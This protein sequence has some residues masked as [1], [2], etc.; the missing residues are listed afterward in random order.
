MKPEFDLPDSCE[1]CHKDTWIASNGICKKCYSE[2][3][4]LKADPERAKAQMKRL[5]KI[6]TGVIRFARSIAASQT[7]QR[8]LELKSRLEKLEHAVVNE[9]NR[10]LTRIFNAR[11]VELAQRRDPHLLDV[12]VQNINAELIKHIQ[13]DSRSIYGISP[14]KF[15]EIIAEIL[16][17]MGCD[18]K[19]M[20][21]TR[22]GG[23]DVLATFKTT[24]GEF[25]AIVQ[26]KRQMPL[27]KVGLSIVERFL[28]TI[29]DKDKASFGLVATTSFFTSGARAK[30]D[31]YKYQL[32]LADKNAVLR[33]IGRYGTWKKTPEAGIWIPN[34]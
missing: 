22:D 17:D 18:V 34:A 33:W 27:N 24:L 28:Y 4:Y 7:S 16:A 26:C 32:K 30:A 9:G 12:H 15:E 10:E 5:S 21:E 13:H 1:R 14:R 8:K 25:L 11:P 6:E 19:L 31:E 2:I 29:R 23:R 20:P 3:M